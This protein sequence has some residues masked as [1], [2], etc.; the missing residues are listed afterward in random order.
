MRKNLIIL[1]L[2]LSTTSLLSAQSLTVHY[3]HVQLQ[4]MADGVKE[5]KDAVANTTIEYDF[6]NRVITIITDGNIVVVVK[7]AYETEAMTIK[8]EEIQFYKGIG[9]IVDSPETFNVLG[10][11][12]DTQTQIYLVGMLAIYSNKTQEGRL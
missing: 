10:G 2:V 3:N 4:R 6:K 5:Y 9:S 7:E 1:F 11:Y 12:S 8:G